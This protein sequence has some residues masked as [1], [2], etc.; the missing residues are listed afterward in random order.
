MRDKYLPQALERAGVDD[1]RMLN[2]TQRSKRY[3]N[4]LGKLLPLISFIVPML[5][6]YSLDPKSFEATW[7]GRTYELFFLW[8]IS[9]ETILNWEKLNAEKRK[10]KSLRTVGFVI[11]LLL[12]TIYVVGDNY[13]GWNEISKKLVENSQLSFKDSMPL[14]NE[15]L[16]FTVLFALII[17]FE[18]G[19]TDLKNYSISTVFLGTIGIIYTIDN[20]YP[21]GQ[22]APFQLI[23]P[24]TTMLAA[25]VLNLM[26][27][28][29]LISFSRANPAHVAL[30]R[31]TISS[32]GRST[33]FDIGWPCSGVES[34][35]IYAVTI[36]LFL[37]NSPI[38]WKQTT[39]YFILGAV[40]TYFI[41]ILRIVII[42]LIS[43]N[44]GG[45]LTPA[46]RQF[47]DYYG[48]LLSIV[49]IISYPLIIIGTRLL[50]NEIRKM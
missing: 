39:I 12:P 19:F 50:W 47:H 20:L 5:I 30:P 14:S 38:S 18:Y 43:F 8:L 44:T 28:T 11:T 41:N 16:V 13:W 10:L 36:L 35:I 15:Y 37:K 4:I 17:L 21:W 25:R 40:I 22:F 7:K 3:A 27:F 46:V 24:T 48:Q 2:T 1:W 45:G 9:L 26:G 49:W 23:V 29:T 42:F 6:L 34:L 32:A 31:L 33:W